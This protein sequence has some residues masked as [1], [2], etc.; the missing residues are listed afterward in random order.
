MEAGRRMARLGVIEHERDLPFLTLAEVR[1]VFGGDHTPRWML[2]A[3]RKAEM[4]RFRAIVPPRYLGS[5]PP[6]ELNDPFM[7]QFFGAPVEP[8][9]D[10]AIVRGL[11]ASR[12]VVTGRARVIRSLA[13]AER[14]EPGDI[15]VC[16]MTTPA[17]TPFFP[18]LGGIVADSGGPLSHCAV[19]SREFCIPCV[20]GT[21][22]GTRQIPDGAVITLD[23]AQGIV[24][25]ES[26]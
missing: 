15:L 23:G 25:I 19:V 3:E 22:A 2:V 1:A 4:E 16:D 12:G 11:A 20:V 8:S 5:R 10:P 6:V 18:I 9:R 24:R 21:G 7:S 14:L 17:W 13:E 26:R